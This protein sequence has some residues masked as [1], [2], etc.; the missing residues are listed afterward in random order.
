M[1]SFA[2]ISKKC[3]STFIDVKGKSQPRDFS[4]CCDVFTLAE[5]RILLA[6]ALHKLD[7]LES[8]YFRRR[9]EAFI[10]TRSK[11]FIEQ[12]R[13]SSHRDLFLPDEYYHM[14]EV[15]LFINC[16]EIITV[17]CAPGTLR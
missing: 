15:S 3:L 16:P 17:R 14:E 8:K 10:R 5:Q 9:R 11:E 1:M 13:D 12:F 4:L 6:T 2:Q 7:S